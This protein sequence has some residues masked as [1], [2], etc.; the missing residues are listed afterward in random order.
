MS[1]T[2]GC[3]G[4]TDKLTPQE[5]LNR[6]GLPALAYRVG[7]HA[8]FF[9]TMLARLTDFVLEQGK[10]ENADVGL[11][12]APLRSLRT[13]ERNDAAIAWLDAWATIAEVLTFYQER[14]ANEGY[15]RTATERRSVLELAKL[16]GYKL[17]PGV[18]ATAYLAFELDKDQNVIIPP[19]VR[20]QSIPGPGE[21]PQ[22]FETSAP[23]EAR[24]AWNAL[25]PR[26]LRPQFMQLD[27]SKNIVSWDNN[28]LLTTFFFKGISTNLKTNDALLFVFAGDAIVHF[29]DSVEPDAEN[30]RTKVTRRLV[31]KDFLV[32]I[33]EAVDS[34]RVA[35]NF[36]VDPNKNTSAKAV[37]AIL[38]GIKAAAAAKT[39][40]ADL[41]KL[42]NDKA[43]AIKEAIG[44]TPPQE[45]IAWTEKIITAFTEILFRI[46]SGQ[47][48]GGDA[49][50]NLQA[51]LEPLLRPPSFQPLNALRRPIGKNLAYQRGSDLA[52][53][54]LSQQRPELQGRLYE[55]WGNAAFSAT[56]PLKAVAAFRIKAAPFGHNAPPL[57][58]AEKD[59]VSEKCIIAGVVTDASNDWDMLQDDDDI[60]ALDSVYEQI[61][62]GSW[63]AIKKPKAS[64][65]EFET[66]IYRV[67]E[68]ETV[69]KVAYGMSS[70]VT[71]LKLDSIWLSKTGQKIFDLRKTTVYAQ[72]ENLELTEEPIAEDV[73]DDGVELEGLFDGIKSGRWLLVS[74]ERT[75]LTNN[76][77]SDKVRASELVMLT[78][79]TQEV[80]PLLVGDTPHTRLHFA[81]GLSYRYKRET[82]TI[83]ANVAHATHGETRP[84]VLGSGEGTLSFQEFKLSQKPLTY[85]AANQTSGVESTL[86][87]RV[88][89]ILWR[90]SEQLSELGPNEQRYVTRQNNE[91]NTFITFGNGVQGARLPTG[92]EN[93]KALYRF[94]LGKAGNVPAEKISLLATRPLGVKGVSNPQASS[95]GADAED[96]DRGRRNA[97]VALKALGRAVS[98]ADYADFARAFAGI[99]KASALRLSDGRRELVHVTVAGANN[100]PINRNSDLY[101]NLKQALFR[102]GDPHVAFE[103]AERE[104]KLILLSAQ[105]RLQPEYLWEVVEPKIRA[106]LL[107]RFGFE[108][109]EL[110]QDVLMSE[111]MSAIHHVPGVDYVD[112][113]VLSAL[114]SDELSNKEVLENIVNKLNDEKPVP[115]TR[116]AVEFT[117][118]VGDEIKPA[119]LA[120][121]SPEAP[122]TL[123]LQER[124]R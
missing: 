63:I 59:P 8:T 87:M 116:V 112:V 57:L 91:G 71:Q 44:G 124:S 32:P 108:A 20:S 78:A 66:K 80:N 93:V 11:H 25:K 38:D 30:S 102:F 119:Q 104:L 115:D 4:G 97:T 3:C 35:E 99:G 33:N 42:L 72:S 76:A 92:V 88:N 109:R 98:V 12:R 64:S 101:R 41:V 13:R 118:R 89:D 77:S 74:G 84:E 22:A 15:L 48:S 2:C 83:N 73:A 39:S 6:P 117:R 67:V 122:D 69:S 79:S 46:S 121:L 107:A 81:R 43:A 106:Q 114:G 23:L 94:G 82:V 68:A 19:G 65:E 52:L 85:K 61:K 26:M 7:T 18:A 113:D 103:V 62:P 123:M 90:E 75:D 5:I 10:G 105:V 55:A 95:G 14:I 45:L 1:E 31:V 36:G 70:R 28:R 29:V 86:E 110:G 49:F 96:L 47:A 51:L 111:V 60:L 53:Q 17:R 9:E 24:F 21:M 100:I 120:I 56:P 37:V 50:A 27:Q 16:V 40:F 58:K 54:L 34:F